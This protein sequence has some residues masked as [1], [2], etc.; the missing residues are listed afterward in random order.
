MTNNNHLPWPS[1]QREARDCFVHGIGHST[2]PNDYLTINIG[3]GDEINGPD[4]IEVYGP[5]QQE[6]AKFIVQA[7]NAHHHLVEALWC[8]RSWMEQKWH[9]AD[10]DQQG[11]R[12]FQI[13]KEKIERARQTLGNAGAL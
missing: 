2:A 7:C 11:T 8:C 9:E 6:N 10:P 13:L 4:E 5:N 1:P 12:E 3:E